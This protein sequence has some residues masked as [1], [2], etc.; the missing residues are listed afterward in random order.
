VLLKVALPQSCPGLQPWQ[1]GLGTSDHLAT[2]TQRN[3]GKL[4]LLSSI[5]LGPGSSQGGLEVLDSFLAKF[6]NKGSEVMCSMLVVEYCVEVLPAL[7]SKY[8]PLQTDAAFAIPCCTM[9]IVAVPVN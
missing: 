9:L 6:V 4:Q 3:A 5:D 1:G 8:L 7:W 2:I